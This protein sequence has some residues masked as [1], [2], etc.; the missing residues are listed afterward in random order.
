MP[1]GNQPNDEFVH[2][3]LTSP[4]YD[5]FALILNAVP[6]ED[7]RLRKS[8]NHD[9]GGALPCCNTGAAFAPW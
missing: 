1:D 3:P 6:P 7:K 8:R 5:G 9:P 2:V 4:Y